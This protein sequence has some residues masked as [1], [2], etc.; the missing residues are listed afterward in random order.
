VPFYLF[1]GIIFPCLALEEHLSCPTMHPPPNNLLKPR[2]LAIYRPNKGAAPL[3][4]V[5]THALRSIL[6]KRSDPALYR[7][8][9]IRDFMAGAA[10]LLL[11]F[12]MEDLYEPETL[13]AGNLSS[14]K[15]HLV[16]ELPCIEIII[17]GEMQ[18]A[19]E[20]GLIPRKVMEDWERAAALVPVEARN[21]RKRIRDFV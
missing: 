2:H 12:G 6:V 10:P 11:D 3:F 13:I 7:L 8:Y 20:I 17:S 5:S 4:N 16:N 21:L 19:V 14:L 1:L 18:R 9:F 15:Q